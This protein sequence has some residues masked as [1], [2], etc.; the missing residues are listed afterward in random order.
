MLPSNKVAGEWSR[1]SNLF[2]E[3]SEEQRQGVREKKNTTRQRKNTFD[4]GLNFLFYDRKT[5]SVQ[6]LAAHKVS[7]QYNQLD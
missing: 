7:P 5:E 3:A 6:Y 1:F 2:V 4:F